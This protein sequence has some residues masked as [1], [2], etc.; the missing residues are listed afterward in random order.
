MDGMDSF[1]QL[2]ADESVLGYSPNADSL[3]DVFRMQIQNADAALGEMDDLMNMADAQHVSI[4]DNM[5]D[6]LQLSNDVRSNSLSDKR[7]VIDDLMGLTPPVDMPA[8]L[9]PDSKV[10]PKVSGC[11]RNCMI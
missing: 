8:V 6:I 3:D 9:P 2:T 7:L 5:D 4:G 10:K 1:M 11:E